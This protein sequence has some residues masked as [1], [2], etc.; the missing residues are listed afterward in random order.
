MALIERASDVHVALLYE[1]VASGRVSLA[2][3]NRTISTQIS[4]NE[5]MWHLMRWGL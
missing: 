2:A 1:E 5:G 3:S 4:L